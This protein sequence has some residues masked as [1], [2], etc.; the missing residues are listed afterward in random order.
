MG[1]RRAAAV[2]LVTLSGPSFV[3]ALC[4]VTCAH[5]EHHGAEAAAQS[6]HEEQASGHGA[7]LT[8]GT[9]TFCHEQAGTVISTSA[10][11]RVPNPAPVVIHLPSALA[12]PR[13]Q[14][15]V[16]ALGTSPSPSPPGIVIR[17]TPLRI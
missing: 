17:T 14:G 2:L 4:D 11:V 13:P 8:D 9:A 16:L 15:R 5:R 12:V 3:S 10:D 1:M 6:C 7:L